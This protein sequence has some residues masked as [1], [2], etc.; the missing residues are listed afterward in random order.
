MFKKLNQIDDTVRNKILKIYMEKCAN[1]Y[2]V[3]FNKWRMKFF[4]QGSG[5]DKD[6]LQ[7][8]LEILAT[9]EEMLFKGTDII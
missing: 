7:A 1:D 2:S 5:V 6:T 3:K 9:K 4:G 8:R